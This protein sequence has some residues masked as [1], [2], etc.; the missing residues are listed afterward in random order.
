MST[1]KRI[2]VVAV[3]LITL[4]GTYYLYFLYEPRQWEVKYGE[5]NAFHYQGNVDKAA[6]AFREAL[7]SSSS[8]NESG[9]T[10]VKLAFQLFQR[11]EGDDRIEAA[12]IYK[13]VIRDNIIHPIIRAHA[14]F[15]L[16]EVYG[17][18]AKDRELLKLAV[19]NDE[20]FSSMLKEGDMN[21]A[22][23]RVYEF[24]NEIYPLPLTQLTIGRS[25]FS[26]YL[27]NSNLSADERT[28]AINRLKL[29]TEAAE[30]NFEARLIYYDKN[31]KAYAYRLDGENHA[32]LADFTD[33]N[34]DRAESLYKRALELIAPEKELWSF[35]EG[36]LVRWDYASLLA[37]R[38]GDGAEERIDGLLNPLYELPPEFKD[39]TLFIHYFLSP[40]N[41][42]VIYRQYI[43]NVMN[44]SA[45]FKNYMESRGWSSTP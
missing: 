42:P 27:R 32:L 3:L 15:E 29:W 43:E 33:K 35:S 34:Y 28:T 23:R 25:Y 14:A 39:R 16:I 7:S 5:G 26:P 19:F 24:S 8:A 30:D 22:V 9:R 40:E 37:R 6:E 4:F 44:V 2:E 38:D 18:L 12:N 17:A 10:K 13:E 41:K 11:N 45:R 20:P 1:T 21:L 31:L 36:L